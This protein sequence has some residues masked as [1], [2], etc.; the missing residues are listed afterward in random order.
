MASVRRKAET[1]TI[2]CGLWSPRL[3]VGIQPYHPAGYPADMILSSM[4]ALA[5]AFTAS[6]APR[7]TRSYFSSAGRST[8]CCRESGSVNFDL[9]MEVT[10]QLKMKC[11][12]VLSQAIPS[13]GCKCGT[14]LTLVIH[15]CCWFGDNPC[16]LVECAYQQATR[17]RGDN[18][19]QRTCF[20]L[21]VALCERRGYFLAAKMRAGKG[22]THADQGSTEWRRRR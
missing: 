11:S 2:H 8:E 10:R 14:S 6:C 12:S 20:F 21:E 3:T 13:P 17:R 19:S 16:A 18:L 15:I 5:I 4:P 1:S 9:C 7:P 22:S